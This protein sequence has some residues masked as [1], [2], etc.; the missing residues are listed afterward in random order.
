MIDVQ[1]RQQD[2]EASRREVVQLVGSGGLL[3]RLL[4]LEEDN[5]ALAHVASRSLIHANGF[6]KIVLDGGRG[7]QL[8]LHYWPAGA[9]EVL[10]NP[11]NHRWDFVTYTLF[12]GYTA[13]LF[14]ASSGSN[15]IEHEYTH[16]GGLAYSLDRLGLVELTPVH[17]NW[18]VKD[19]CYWM[20]ADVIHAVTLTDA[21]QAT[22]TLVRVGPDVKAGT[23]VFTPSDQGVVAVRSLPYQALP[24]TELAKT[25][26]E[27]ISGLGQVHVD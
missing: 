22:A 11:H 4:A 9:R 2:G 1:G 27:I 18:Y 16:P 6:Q 17:T 13:S 10:E 25:L 23:R 8:R 21:D 15:W 3:R 20:H 5:N 26:K 14:L 19:S 7:G 24:M 12:G